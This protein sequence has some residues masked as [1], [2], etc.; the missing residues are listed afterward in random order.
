MESQYTLALMYEKGEGDPTKGPADAAIWY[1][2]AAQLGLAKAQFR[3]AEIY[4]NGTGLPQDPKE[5]L[6]WYKKAAEENANVDAMVALGHLYEQATAISRKTRKKRRS[7]IRRRPTRG[8][9]V[10]ELEMARIFRDNKDIVSAYK[11]YAIATN[12]LEGDLKASAIRSRVQL[13]AQMTPEQQIIARN[14]I[15]SLVLRLSL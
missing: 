5:A 15:M 3:L 6:K 11:W 12:N 10:A 1:S 4:E 8:D 7:G 13:S 2:H 14:G 9:G